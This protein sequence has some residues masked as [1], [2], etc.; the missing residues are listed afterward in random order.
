MYSGTYWKVYN[1]CFMKQKCQLQ[2][3]IE[4]YRNSATPLGTRGINT[5][6]QHFQMRYIPLFLAQGA[7]KLSA[8]KF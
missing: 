3:G 6:H 1:Y 8:I 4:Q 7:K 5:R 2:M